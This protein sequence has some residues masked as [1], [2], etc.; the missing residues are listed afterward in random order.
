MQKFSSDVLEVMHKPKHIRNISVIA[1]V[2]HGKTTL[3]DSL[4]AHA[5]IISEADAGTK[6]KLDDT[7]EEKERGITIKSTGISM[8]YEV[9]D[10]DAELVDG[11][12]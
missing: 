6:R 9:E 3:C 1:H 10:Y 7:E 11:H 8:Y 4:M 12:A 2:D 5:G